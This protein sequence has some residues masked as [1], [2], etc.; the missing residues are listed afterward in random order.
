MLKNYLLVT[1]RNL[2]KNRIFALINIL[3]LGIALSVCIVA[4]FNAMFDYE[5]DRGH[6]NFKQIYRVTSFRDM[7]GRAQEYGIVPA[8]LGLE[9]ES[10]IPGVTK[11]A[12]L[13]RSYTPVKLGQDIFNRHVSYVDPQFLDIFT[14][15][16]VSGHASAIQNPDMVLISEDLADDLFGSDDPTG[17][18]ISLFNDA[19]KEFAYTVGGVFHDLPQNSSFR[20]DVLTHFDNFLQMWNIENVDWRLMVRALFIMVSDESD[21]SSIQGSLNQYVPAQNKARE[22]FLITGYNLVPL[23]AMGDN[24]RKIWSSS[25]FPGLHPAAVLAPP[26]MAIMILLI[27]VFNFANTAIASAGKRLKEIGIRK[28]VGG[29][30]K[31]LMVQ[32]L[33]ENFIICFLALLVGIGLASF[34]VPA[35]SSLWEYMTIQLTF[36]EYWSF[37]LFI[38]LLLMVTGMLAGTYPALYISSFKPVFI[39]Q[40]KTRLGSAGTFSRILLSL[41]LL[42]SVLAIVSGIIFAKNAR[43]QETVDLGYDRDHLIVVPV[44]TDHFQSFREAIIQNPKITSV[45]GTQEHIGFGNYTRPLKDERQQM[46]VGVMDVGP[47]YMETMGLRLLEGRGFDPARVDAD[48]QGAIVINNEMVEAFGWSDPIGK[49]VTMSDTSRLRVIGIVHDFY[50]SGLWNEIEPTLIRLTP[51]ERYF[52]MAV[53]SSPG[54]LPEVLD[55][56][57]STWQDMFPNYPFEGLYQEDTLQ[58]EKY[59]N[60]S[61]MKVFLFLAV[62]A[63]VL[64]MIG[65]YTLISLSV[66][67]RKK[68]IGIR[69]VL[70]ASVPRIILLVSKVFILILAIA[71]VLG[72]IGGN[73]LSLMLLDSIWDHFLNITADIFILALLLV[74]VTA[75]LT[76]I[77]KV[78]Y[79]AVQNPAESLRYE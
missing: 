58:E 13:F 19:N 32:F 51:E 66:L 56:L 36:S 2:Y 8:M 17:K 39:L 52:N 34:L 24:S 28:V 15:P 48:R 7:Q 27:A 77:G 53:R 69:K 76:M 59:I 23:R 29:I 35:Y 1:I 70:G 16:L 61:I 63:T 62:V 67:N 11:A 25:M 10:D 42:I 60:R 65:L 31:Q 41:Q 21:R 47:H 9:M 71:S 50:F 37:W 26:V 18:T 4:Y 73:Y 64:S 38:I 57:R 33:I 46:E 5:F 49:Q 78:Y 30:R 74:F 3:G 79:A 75:G 55:Y 6:E 43:Y 68:E 14:F 54:D 20:I 22:D 12:R 72:C 45:A 40:G 44:Q